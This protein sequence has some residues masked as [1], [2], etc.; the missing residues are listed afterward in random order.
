MESST[1]DAPAPDA[2]AILAR[3]MAELGVVRDMQGGLAIHRAGAGPALVLL[4]GG[5]GSWTHWLR[6]ID[7]LSRHFTVL[8]VDQ[9]GFG[10]SAA[11]PDDVDFDGYVGM[12]RA[13]LDAAIGKDAPVT[14]VC[15]SF[16]GTI[17]LGLAAGLGARLRK[18]SLLAPGGFGKP[19]GRDLG[20]RRLRDDMTAAEKR[21]VYRH[22]LRAMMLA[23]DSSIDDEILSL[24]IRNI[25]LTRFRSIKLSHLAVIEDLLPRIA[26]PV[27]MLWGALD[28]MPWPSLAHRIGVCRAVRPDIEVE[29][30]ADAGHWAQ[31]ER[32][33]DYN[34]LVLD[35]LLRSSAP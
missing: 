4:H 32:A 27:Q 13:A 33:E 34:R 22:N 19:T 12:I 20:N 17:G 9:P 24:H 5:T 10:R 7:A 8:A 35:F 16:G 28:P 15:F 6:N 14:L 31:F 11:P 3:R 2:E 1:T 25:R 26:C 30:I 21:A 18:L 29:I 23:H